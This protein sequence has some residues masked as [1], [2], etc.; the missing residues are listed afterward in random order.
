[1]A[2]HNG[3]SIW[4]PDMSPASSGGQMSPAQAAEAPHV[5][6]VGAALRSGDLQI[7]AMGMIL[8][9]LTW[10][11]PMH[12]A[13][14]YTVD[15]QLEKYA[16]GPVVASVS[17]AF[18]RDLDESLRHHV[19]HN[20]ARDPFAPARLPDPNITLA[21][22]RDLGEASEWYVEE[23][24]STSLRP[25]ANMYFRA[26]GRVVAGISLVRQLQAPELSPSEI[27]ALRRLHRY[28]G[29]SYA[30]CAL[31]KSQNG[32]GQ[33]P[34]HPTLTAREREIFSL[35]RRGASYDSIGHELGISRAT[36][37]THVKH[38]FKKLGVANRYEAMVAELNSGSPRSAAD[39]AAGS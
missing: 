29:F 7:R 21:T 1:M 17:S 31:V 20:A 10:L 36:V 22:P 35:M 19:E 3:P 8:D 38:M 2:A 39:G 25:A 16:R 30:A 26:A 6:R 9:H 34:E 24:A 5:L 27:A 37:K 23:L 28:F 11:V 15:E 13:M 4:A 14:F 33:A 12:I 32:N 18:R